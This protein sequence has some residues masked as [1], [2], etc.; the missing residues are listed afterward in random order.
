MVWFGFRIFALSLSAGIAAAAER[1]GATILP[2]PLTSWHLAQ[3]ALAKNRA[4]PFATLPDTSS[5]T[6]DTVPLRLR[7]YETSCQASVIPSFWKAGIWVPV[8][9]LR[10]LRKISPSLVPCLK[11]PVASAGPRSLP[12]ALPPWHA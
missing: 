1:S 8:I 2:R 9:P 6:F 4:S 5:S 12:A 3:A 7:K 10:M 11:A